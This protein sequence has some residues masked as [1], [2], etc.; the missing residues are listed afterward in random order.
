[1]SARD[2]HL[3]WI[4]HNLSELTA[5][6]KADLLTTLLDRDEVSSHEAWLQWVNTLPTET[7][8]LS[9]P[10]WK[11]LWTRSKDS[12]MAPIC[13]NNSDAI[14]QY[15]KGN[16]FFTQGEKSPGIV[17]MY[18]FFPRLADKDERIKEGKTYDNMMSDAVSDEPQA[19]K[20]FEFH[21]ADEPEARG[22]LAFEF[23]L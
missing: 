22:H 15:V 14:F 19:H 11:T 20:L 17:N 6:Q 2:H 7:T 21:A 10:Q 23:N 1:M 8:A 5:K 16:P 9:G 4:N 18:A 3:Q 12:F 13:Q